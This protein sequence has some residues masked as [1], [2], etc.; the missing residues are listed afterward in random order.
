MSEEEKRRKSSCPRVGR[1]KTNVVQEVLAGLKENRPLAKEIAQKG[2]SSSIFD[3]Q[4]GVFKVKHIFWSDERVTQ[5][6]SILTSTT[7]TF[8]TRLIHPYSLCELGFCLQH[9]RTKKDNKY[10]PSISSCTR[11][12]QF[13]VIT[14]LQFARKIREASNTCK[15]RS[16]AIYKTY[17]SS[18]WE[19]YVN[20][21]KV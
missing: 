18:V 19:K 7:D 4:I 1:R 21:T 2:M 9:E 10:A 14:I 5:F 13:I 11:W 3:K 15:S 16:K 6:S 17:F 12:L 20:T 8:I